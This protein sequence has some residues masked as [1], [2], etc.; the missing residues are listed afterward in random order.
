MK[1]FQI[2]FPILVILSFSL[3]GSSILVPNSSAQD[4]QIPNWIKNTAGWWATD[5]IS[6]TEF[7]NAIEFLVN[8]GII[9][10]TSSSSTISNQQEVPD[11]IKNTAGW[12]ATDAISE[13]E[14]VNSIQ[15]LIKQGIISLEKTGCGEDVDKDRNNIPDEIENLPNLIG[16]T[17]TALSKA[18]TTFSDKDWSNCKIPPNMAYYVFNNI[19]LTDADLSNTNL[20]MAQFSQSDLTRTNFSNSILHGSVFIYSTIVDANFQNTDFS[21]EPYE[22]PFVHFSITIKNMEQY[23]VQF[24]CDFIPCFYYPLDTPEKTDEINTLLFGEKTIPLNLKYIKQINDLSDIRFVYRVV[25]NFSFNDI[26]NTNFQNSD[27]SNV[28]FRNNYLKNLDFSASDISKSLFI[29]S[30]IENAI[31]KD[32]TYLNSPYVRLIQNNDEKL[33]VYPKILIETSDSKINKSHTVK[34]LKT[35]DEPP[36]YFS[37]GM[38]VDENKLYVANTDDHEIHIYDKNT[39]ELISDFSSPIQ[40]TCETTNGY[41][42]PTNCPYQSRNLPTS[43]SIMDKNI[44]VLYG[45]ANDIQIFDQSGNFVKTFGTYGKNQG[46]F[47]GA[48]DLVSSENELFVL[49]S[50]NSRIQ[51]FDP[52]G[53]YLR[54]FSV[55]IDEKTDLI[56][57]D[58]EIYDKKLFVVESTN[59][60]ILQFNFNGDLMKRI[61]LSDNPLPDSII[62][63]SFNGEYFIIADQ[64][65]HKI[66]IY[67]PSGNFLL[68]FGNYGQLFGQFDAPQD[69]VFDGEKI[70]VSDGYNHRLQIF[71]LIR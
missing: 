69:V 51:I 54:E 61:T 26:I 11:W 67:D 49:D 30:K 63:I 50:G 41:V 9:Q 22:K 14:F 4:A 44:F 53:E 68:S 70:F 10:I 12:W 5:A 42:P 52:M 64:K 58:L 43:L 37:M 39:F 23:T 19:D 3:L 27:L 25:S 16:M 17:D 65:M 2:R 29:H 6:E 55:N 28:S 48:F 15:F 13:T 33:Y 21:L 60:S 59:S 32:Q 24:N 34:L 35:I 31:I 20:F 1:V 18:I 47:D 7:L 46:E 36:I 56:F 40:Y 8:V 38:L 57:A 71:D 62:D 45:F 66:S